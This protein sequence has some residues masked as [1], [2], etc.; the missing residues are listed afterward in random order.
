MSCRG[1]SVGPV[2]RHKLRVGVIGQTS[3]LRILHALAIALVPLALAVVDHPVVSFTGVTDWA[4]LMDED[5]L[6]REVMPDRSLIDKEAH[7]RKG[8]NW[9]IRVLA[10][11]GL[12][13]AFFQD[14]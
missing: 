6:Q 8:G 5:G 11:Q 2:V 10:C 12:S 7:I 14:G 4:L 9:S 13:F 1:S 3:G